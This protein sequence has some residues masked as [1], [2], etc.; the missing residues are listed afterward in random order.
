MVILKQIGKTVSICLKQR[1]RGVHVKSQIEVTLLL[2]G[3]YLQYTL[4]RHRVRPRISRPCS[5]YAEADFTFSVQIWVDTIAS[6]LDESN[7]WRDYQ[8][9][10]P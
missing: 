2:I 3:F 6:V 4:D 7:F 10:S 1:Q 5:Q 9:I 8:G